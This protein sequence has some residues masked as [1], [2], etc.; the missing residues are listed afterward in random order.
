MRMDKDMAADSAQGS[1]IL[2]FFKG[3]G[4]LQWFRVLRGCEKL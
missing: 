4:R 1:Y 3:L 2:S